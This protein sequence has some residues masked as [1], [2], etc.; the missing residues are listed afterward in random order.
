MVFPER[1]EFC[2]GQQQ[3]ELRT[4]R[5][6]SKHIA[7]PEE[8]EEAICWHSE[9]ERAGAQRE[10]NVKGAP[11]LVVEILSPGTRKRDQTLK[12]NLFDRQGVREYWIVDP[13]RNQVTVYRRAEDGSFELNQTLGARTFDYKELPPQILQT[14]LLPGW[15]L[16]LDRLFR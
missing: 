1:S 14:P 13:D 11:G 15:S 7:E 3:Q 5:R 9:S 12:R 8:N 2:R 16:S 10:A 4:S 6:P